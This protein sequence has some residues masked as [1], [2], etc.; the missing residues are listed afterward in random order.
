MTLNQ[1]LSCALCDHI[2]R[3]KVFT[4]THC[5]V[6]GNDLIH[7]DGVSHPDCGFCKQREVS[8]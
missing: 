5:S 8:E 7:L 6:T 4:T 1:C 3:Q 2:N